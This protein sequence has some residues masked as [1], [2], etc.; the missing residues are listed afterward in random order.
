MVKKLSAADYVHSLHVW[1]HAAVTME[2]FV[3]SPFDLFLSPTT[4]DTAPKITADLQSDLNRQQMADVPHLSADEGLAVVS[5]M[6]EES[7]TITPYTQ[8]ANL[9]GQP[10]ISLPTHVSEQG[11]PLGFSL[12]LPEERRLTV[13]DW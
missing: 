9:T 3:W 13:S 10:A 12:W 5:A 8:L 4:A 7:L 1:D 2:S 11:L 6:L